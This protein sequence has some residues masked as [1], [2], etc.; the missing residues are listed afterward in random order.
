[1]TTQAPVN[2]AETFADV[3]NAICDNI[4]LA[5]RGKR[6]VIHLVVVS[7][8]AEGHVLALEKGQIGEAYILAGPSLTFREAM[9]KWEKITGVPAPR[10][11]LP[12]WAAGGM[13]Q[14]VGLLERAFGLRTTFSS[15]ALNSLADYTFFGSAEKAKRELCWQPRPVEETFREA[16][17]AIRDQRP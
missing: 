3:F 1:M 13:A 6:D 16:L 7:L 14:L 9:Q 12:G 17:K 15:E 2:Q 11:W 10:M 4:E 8:L 5:I